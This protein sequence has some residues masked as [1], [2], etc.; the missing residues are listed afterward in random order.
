M[1]GGVAEKYSIKVF[2]SIIHL[3]ADLSGREKPAP[4]YYCI[5]IWFIKPGYG[6]QK[7]FTLKQTHTHHTHTHAHTHA[8]THTHHTRTHT[9]TTHTHQT[10]PH[11]HARTHARTAH[12]TPQHPHHTHTHT[13]VGF[14]CF[15]G[16]F[17]RRN[18]FYCTNCIFYPL[19][20]PYP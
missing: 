12:H 19:H 2:H 1:Q 16:T 13:H 4:A 17:H 10:T 9:H 5:S 20:C 8:R 18:G 11:T 14:P 3:R 15:M 6:E 7:V